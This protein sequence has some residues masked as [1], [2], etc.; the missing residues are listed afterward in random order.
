ME[1][2]GNE[3]T[4]LS[5]HHHPVTTHPG[6]IVLVAQHALVDFSSALALGGLLATITVQVSFHLSEKLK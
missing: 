6:C 2:G 4:V 1:M 3:L 5:V